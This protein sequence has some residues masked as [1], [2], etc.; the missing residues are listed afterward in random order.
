[1][2]PGDMKDIAP[3]G[4]GVCVL[5]A[6]DKLIFRTFLV[7][8]LRKLG[9]EVLTAA[10][11]K[12]AVRKFCLETQPIVFFIR[13]IETVSE[14]DCRLIRK[15]APQVRI[16]N[17]SSHTFFRIYDSDWDRPGRRQGT[18]TPSEFI[19]TIQEVLLPTC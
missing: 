19:Q 15:I 13:D 1:M 3:D 14:T 9:Y 5:V 11:G 8:I 7:T 2:K 4:Q 16:I 17:I 18:L 6:E 10:D 12:D